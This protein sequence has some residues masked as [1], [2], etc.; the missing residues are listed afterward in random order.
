MAWEFELCDLAGVTIGLL[1]PRSVRVTRNLNA[2]SSMEL[3]V[4]S[5]PAL[6]TAAFVR[7]W[8][9]PTAGGARVVRATGKIQGGLLLAAAR[10][11]LETLDIVATDGY[12]VLADRLVQAAATY[13][14]TTP[15]DIVA[16]LITDQNARAAT[17]LAAPTNDAGPPRDRSYD[18]GKNVA[19]AIAQLAEV[20]DGFYFRVDPTEDAAF[21][22]LV[23]LH[24]APGN[25]ETASFEFGEGTRANLARIQV[26]VRPPVNHVLAF[27][28]GSGDAQLVS[29]QSDAAS[30]AEY[31][32]FDASASFS[33]VVVQATLD[34]HA[35]DML[36]PAERRT[37][38][39]EVASSTGNGELETP[40]PWDGFD[41]GDTVALNLRTTHL[42]YTGRALVKSFTVAIDADGVERLSALDFQEDV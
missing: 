15:G 1:R 27:G 28:A 33:D 7:G 3:T 10:D 4:D 37:F 26:D 40:S 42:T 16:D 30:I 32:L 36:R 17:G 23:L 31:G 25:D 8:R 9:A 21:S 34:Q 19:E 6:T 12:G 14:A 29:A 20:D 18:P 41:V 5:A 13:T 39:V 22:Q 24:P 35:L 2:A 11:A 38:R